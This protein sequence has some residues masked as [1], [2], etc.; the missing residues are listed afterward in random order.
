MRNTVFS[1]SWYV[2]PTRGYEAASFLY[3]P[4]ILAVMVVTS[5]PLMTWLVG[6]ILSHFAFSLSRE[7]G[8]REALLV[9]KVV[10]VAVGV[11]AILE[12]VCRDMSWCRSG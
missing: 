4:G 5:V 1:L 9:G 3:V 12:H 6:H 10:S 8:V 11:A 7:G 2:M